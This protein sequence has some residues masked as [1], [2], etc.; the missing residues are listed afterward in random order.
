[1][2]KNSATFF[3]RIWEQQIHVNV[4][5]P[6][7]WPHH[8]LKANISS[9][10]RKP[11]RT[12]AFRPKSLWQIFQKHEEAKLYRLKHLIAKFEMP[13]TFPSIS[14]STNY[15]N[16]WGGFNWNKNLNTIKNSFSLFFFLSMERMLKTSGWDS[17][18]KDVKT[19][20]S[21][22]I[23]SRIPLV[24]PW[25]AKPEVSSTIAFQ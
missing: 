19:I 9:L 20:F 22:L 13:E 2:R 1:M 10:N 25:T 11:F 12:R 7:R 14:K 17:K 3:C 16:T 24:K 23:Y 4:T 5:P 8:I 18:M 6:D 15:N 21:K